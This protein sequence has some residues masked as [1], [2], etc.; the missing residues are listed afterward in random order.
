[1][2][3]IPCNLSTKN[4]FGALDFFI[5]RTAAH[6]IR[7]PEEET[8]LGAQLG[9]DVEKSCLPG[10]WKPPLLRRRVV[11]GIGTRFKLSYRKEIGLV[12]PVVGRGASVSSWKIQSGFSVVC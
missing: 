6:V 7:F 2:L 1:M 5:D 11:G 9:E 4:Y 3:I 8:K 12:V 10:S